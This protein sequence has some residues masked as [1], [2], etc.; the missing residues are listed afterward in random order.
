MARF[1]GL[2]WAMM[3]APLFWVAA[4]TAFAQ[5]PAP[6]A[7]DA[8][9]RGQTVY[10]ASCGACHG[11]TLQGG[12]GGPTLQGGTFRARWIAPPGGVLLRYVREKMPPGAAG[13]LGDQ[14]YADVAAYLH[15]VNGAPPPA[16][17]ATGAAP[18]TVP[19]LRAASHPPDAVAT[20]ALAR[21][22]ALLASLRPVTDALL[23]NPPAGAWLNWRGAYAGDGFSREARINRQ[24][25][26]RLQVAW[27][28][29]LASGT[30][31]ITPLVHDGVLFVVS[32]G[33]LQAL[34][35]R[36][37]D[38]LWQYL[39]PGRNGLVRN[40]AIYGELI[41]YAAETN[42]VALDMR[43][44]KVVWDRQVVE[45]GLGVRFGA[46][47]LA[48]NG[49]IFQGL[50]NCYAPYPGGCFIVALDAATGQEVWRFNTLPRPDQPGGDTWNG[51][52]AAERF[53]GSIWLAPSYDPDLDLV[54][55]GVG[56]TY[57]TATL[58]RGPGVEDRAAG[59]HTDSTLAFRAGTGEL[60]WSY[61]HMQGDIW[62]QDWAFER[63]LATIT[64]DG[65][66]RR[67][68]TTGNKLGIFDTLDA[69]T[70]KYLYSTDL[71]LQ[72]L[73]KTIDPRT[74]R[75]TI[76]PRFA[77]EAGV[78]KIMCS[79]TLGGRDWPATAYNPASGVLFA[80]LNET[81]MGLTWVPG[82]AFDWTSRQLPGSKDGM[83]GRVQAF[84]LATGKTL[85]TARERPHHVSAILA[86]AGGLIFEGNKERWFRARDDRTGKVLWQV[87]LDASPSSFPI[88]YSVDGEQYVAVTTGGGN[89][90]ETG[91]GELT[92]EIVSPGAGGVTLWVFK[93][94]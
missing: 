49:K 52:P 51:A 89:P 70:G 8:A 57:R 48:A 45:P 60:V 7:P 30:N 87:R 92:P 29:Q 80:P 25:V 88:T 19:R 54:Y 79:G 71:G 77:P 43:T 37:G 13:S 14:A 40:L 74:G 12:P 44:G 38:L 81:C 56:Q 41:Y 35:A 84:D 75:K 50:G 85:W 11:A 17:A 39:R 59:L 1:G 47:P 62:D 9:Q 67:T 73:V 18:A 21:R 2:V 4:P 94:P 16:Q 53:G 3:L 72:N 66:P 20:A 82:G 86:T 58:F 93:L 63:T 34:D 90:V 55:F 76:D 24:N 64:V 26:A 32:S 65:K 36:T 61:Q 83:V 15:K 10:Q 6:G 23:R 33:R 31:E 22:Q 68:I 28:W 5:S 91:L 78:E 42:V 69:A 27:A 46:G